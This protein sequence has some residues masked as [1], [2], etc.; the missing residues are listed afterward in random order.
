[1]QDSFILTIASLVATTGQMAQ[2]ALLT[3]FLGL[4]EYGVFALVVSAVA[5]INR[6]FDVQVGSTAIAFAS[7]TA[8]DPQATAS[9]FRFSYV[10]DAAAG[11]AGYAVVVAL[12]PTIG[13]RLAGPQGSTL[14]LLYGLILLTSTIETTSLAVLQLLRR[15]GGILR[16][17]ILRE[18]LRGAFLVTFLL[19]FD[20]LQAA[21][22]A[23][24]IVE[25]VFCVAALLTAVA[26]FKSRYGEH[27]FATRT[28]PIDVATRRSMLAMIFH[29]N[30]IAYA[31]LISSQVPTILLGVL[32]SPVDVGTFKIAMALAAGVGKPADPAWS[33]V[34]PRLSRLWNEGRIREAKSLVAQSTVLAVSV[35]ASGAAVVIVFRDDLIR[36]FA[37]GEIPSGAVDVLLIGI[38]AQVISGT[39]FW[40]SAL[41]IAARRARLASQSYAATALLLAVLL[42]TLIEAYGAEGAAVALLISTLAGNL[43]LTVAALGLLRVVPDSVASAPTEPT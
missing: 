32:R 14:F 42:P 37:G 15:F 27:Y 38:A 10:I 12:A 1:V 26:A 4:R 8:R 6:F 5:I 40:N 17:T 25:G 3:H 20:T 41:L 29:T 23:L 19:L 22:I 33:A 30:F 16:L 31:K 43:M 9:I 21:V 2:I 13:D 35:L 34:L 18:V 28:P 11:V 39:V 24:V 7:K 36:F